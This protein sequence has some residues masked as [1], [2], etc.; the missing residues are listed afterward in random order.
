M[1]RSV[2]LSLLSLI[3]LLAWPMAYAKGGMRVP[4]NKVIYRVTAEQWVTTDI[5]RVIVSV[6]ATMDKSGLAKASAGIVSNLNR[7]AKGEWHITR[8]NRSQD[9]SGLERISV[10]AEAR[11]PEKMLAT[12]RSGAKSVSRPGATYRIINIDFTPSNTEVEKVREKVRASLYNTIKAELQQLNQVYPNQKFMVYRVNFLRGAKLR[13]RY[14]SKQAVQRSMLAM[15]ESP[16]AI[17]V[18]NKVKMTA[19]VIFAMQMSQVA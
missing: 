16:A 1:K 6:S 12:V 14:A 11:I 17:S 3:L 10:Q 5:A 2:Y 8:F 18:S 13:A 19:L 15:A 9:S 7:I 4:L